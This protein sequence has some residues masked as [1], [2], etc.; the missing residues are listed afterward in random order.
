MFCQDGPVLYIDHKRPYGLY[1]KQLM[2][3]RTDRT[4]TEIFQELLTEESEVSVVTSSENISI[5]CNY[6]ERE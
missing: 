1:K 4:T 2:A 5:E 3:V 6:P